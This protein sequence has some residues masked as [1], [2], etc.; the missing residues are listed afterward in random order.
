MGLAL[1]A[2]PWLAPSFTRTSAF[3]MVVPLRYITQPI[4]VTVT[5]FTGHVGFWV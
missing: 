5:K 2:I 3:K 1:L 4:Y